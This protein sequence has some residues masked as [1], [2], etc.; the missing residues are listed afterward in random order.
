MHACFFQKLENQMLM[1]AVSKG[2]KVVY[3]TTVNCEHICYC[4]VCKGS[5]FLM[6][7]FGVMKNTS[8]HA[9]KLKNIPNFEITC[10]DA[11]MGKK[12]QVI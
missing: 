10:L 1:I 6:N 8:N 7:G 5:L 12:K 4:T 9:C 11:E 3:I 2:E